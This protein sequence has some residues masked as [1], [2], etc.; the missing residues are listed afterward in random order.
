MSA[1]GEAAPEAAEPAVEAAVE[2][3]EEAPKRT[4]K[5]DGKPL[6]D[7][8][9]GEEYTGTVVGVAN[10]GAFVDIGAA[11]DG[12]VHISEL[13]DRFVSDVASI[14]SVGDEVNVRVMKCDIEKKQLSL[15]MKPEGAS[16][17]PSSGGRGDRRSGGG[18]ARAAAKA[19]ALKQ[20]IGADPK[21]FIAGTVS[22]VQSWGAF[23]NVA[24][25]LDGLCHISRIADERTENVEDVLTVGQAV[26]VRVIDVD[27]EK[28]TL[29]LAMDTYREPRAGGGGEDGGDFDSNTGRKAP[30]FRA[31][32]GSDDDSSN[33]RPRMSRAEPGDDMWDT[34]PHEMFDWK[35]TMDAVR[36]ETEDEDDIAAFTVD[37]ETGLLQLN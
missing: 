9:E 15:S 12:L 20:F 11:A 22:N 30:K 23:I 33:D 1:E 6:E 34:K 4:S 32:G 26:Q 24:D 19:E 5:E 27:T 36:V 7:I 13:S 18:G 25:G 35:A 16:A 2:A 37:A 3:S 14:V 8:K 21:E 17:A 29:A 28:G 31:A 10:Y